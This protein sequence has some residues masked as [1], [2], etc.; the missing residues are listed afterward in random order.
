MFEQVR[1]LL[2]KYYC[3][4]LRKGMSLRAENLLHEVRSRLRMLEWLHQ[5]LVSLDR[6]LEAEGRAQ[7]PASAPA[8]DVFKQVFTDSERPDCADFRHARLSASNA[9]ELRI[10]LEAFY[11]CAHRTRDIFRDSGSEL[12]GMSAFESVGVRNVRN[13]LVEHPAGKEGVIVNTFAA[14]GPV[15]PELKPL[16]WSLDPEGTKDAGL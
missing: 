3:T 1:I 12:P 15:G 16:R 11:Y 7:L 10:L 5:R 6:D 8:P 13:H 4:L 2:E 14:G 9:D